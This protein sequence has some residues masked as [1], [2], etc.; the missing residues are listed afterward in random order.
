MEC[1]ICKS[2]D[3]P[4]SG[5]YYLSNRQVPFN[6]GKSVYRV[7]LIYP[8]DKPLCNACRVKIVEKAYNNGS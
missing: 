8:S 1:V 6:V 7:R 2:D 3:V 4:E 5:G